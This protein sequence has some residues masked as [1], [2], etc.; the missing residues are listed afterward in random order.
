MRYASTSRCRAEPPDP[1]ADAPASRLTPV[2]KK[3]RVA[4]RKFEDLLDEMFREQPM[5]EEELVSARRDL[6]G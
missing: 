6:Y 1:T 4:R 2:V 3:P 5:T